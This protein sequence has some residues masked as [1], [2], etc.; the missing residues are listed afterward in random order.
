MDNKYVFISYSHND[1]EKVVSIINALKARGIDIWYDEGIEAGTEWPEY[2]A[3]KIYGASVFIAF[4]TPSAAASMNCRNEINYAI[5]LGK[6][7]LIVYL[8][9]TTLSAGMQLQ[10]GSIQAMFYNRSKN[11]EEF[12]ENL[13]R[14]RI[15][16]NLLFADDPSAQKVTSI[17]DAVKQQ[18]KAS[19]PLT[20]VGVPVDNH[21]SEAS[22]RDC[23]LRLIYNILIPLIAVMA[24]SLGVLEMHLVTKY[25]ES[26]FLVFLLGVI[27]PLLV[28]VPFYTVCRLKMQG[29]SSE[30][31]SHIDGSCYA[32]TLI[33]FIVQVI[34]DASYI[35]ST[36]K[37]FLK[38]LISLGINI[39][40]YFITF[41]TVPTKK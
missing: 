13:L 25:V 8:E 19:A 4:M 26:G 1:S 31:C 41:I 36:D 24:V 29:Y 12:I 22:D 35:H 9:P 3:E 33:A 10:L 28:F 11:D 23:K 18:E 40:A 6:E 20:T 17:F 21:T 37:V 27:A 7:M 38:I 34:A 5:S 32:Y 39:V 16:Q 14:S 2:I 30:V 15:L